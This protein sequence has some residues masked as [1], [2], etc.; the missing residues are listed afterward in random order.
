[1]LEARNRHYTDMMRQFQVYQER[2]LRTE[3]LRAKN[4]EAKLQRKEAISQQRLKVQEINRNK[5]T[6]VKELIR[7]KQAAQSLSDE[8]NSSKRRLHTQKQHA[9]DFKTIKE[10]QQRKALERLKTRYAKTIAVK[11]GIAQGFEAKIK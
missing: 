4:A 3:L 2:G 11:Q 6:E 10:A 5:K 7:Q 1:M 8:D 9:Q